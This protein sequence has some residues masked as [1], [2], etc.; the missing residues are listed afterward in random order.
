MQGLMFK[1]EMTL[2]NLQGK[3]SRTSRTK[4]LQVIND[5]PDNWTFEYEELGTYYFVPKDKHCIARM[6]KCPFGKVGSELY[7]KETYTYVTLA[8]KDPWKDRAIADGSFRRM[9]DGSPVTMIYKSD[10]VEIPASWS[11]PMMMPEWA[12][13]YHI[14]LNKIVCQRLHDISEEDSRCEGL[15]EFR[16]ARI[17]FQTLWDSINSKVRP[18]DRLYTLDDKSNRHFI[19]GQT[20]RY[21]WESN[22]WVWALYYE[23]KVK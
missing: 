7:G 15:P 6:V 4:G 13:R 9:P 2:A 19:K 10:G 8:E 18:E 16:P 11:S 3:K 17:Q 14:I 20:G 23:V 5:N 22:P 21:S 1:P 12:S